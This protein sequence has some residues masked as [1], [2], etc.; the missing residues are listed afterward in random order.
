M[1]EDQEIKTAIELAK[2]IEFLKDDFQV[3]KL[4][5]KEDKIL[6]EMKSWL[7]TAGA[8]YPKLMVTNVHPGYRGVIATKN[9]KVD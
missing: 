8:T 9:I 4:T 1:Q 5:P 6:N 2:A 7:G 3:H